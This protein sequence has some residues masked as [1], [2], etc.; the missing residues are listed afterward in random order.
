MCHFR[1]IN[2]ITQCPFFLCRLICLH[3]A[4]DYEQYKCNPRDPTC[5]PCEQR[6]P[7]CSGLPDGKNAYPN[8]VISHEYIVCEKGRTVE[9]GGCLAGYFDPLERDCVAFPHG[10]IS[11]ILFNPLYTEQTP[12]NIY[13]K[14]P[15][16]F[17][18]CQAVIEIFL[19][20]SG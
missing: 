20:K 15:V 14:S 19:E 6:M 18:V 10:K 2:R 17:W 4:G 12:H 13:W 7:S 8:T 3:I 1:I 9:V 11:P 5:S 16:L